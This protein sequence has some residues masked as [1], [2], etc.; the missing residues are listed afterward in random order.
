MVRNWRVWLGVAVSLF[1]AALFIYRVDPKDM[2]RTLAG[3]E[4]LLAIPGGLCYLGA[5]FLRSIRWRYLVRPIVRTSAPRLFPILTIGYALSNLLPL[6]VGELARAYYLGEEEGVS[7]TAA[8]ATV[9]VERVFDGLTLLFLMAAVSLFTP[10]LGQLGALK[11]HGLSGPIIIVVLSLPFLLGIAVLLAAVYF[12]RA[13]RKLLGLLPRR[14][15]EM[16][17]LFIEGLGALRG[18]K[19]LAVI[20]VLSLIVWLA[21]GTVFWVMGH[22]F[23]LPDLLGSRT[24]LL[25]AALLTMALANLVTALPSSSGGVGPF[26][27]FAQATLAFLGVPL[28]VA[29]AYAVAVHAVLILSVTSVGLGFLWWR[30]LPIRGLARRAEE[31]TSGTAPRRSPGD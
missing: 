20:F 22:A 14:L 12:P 9:V 4:Y 2:V 7:K 21:D 16:G 18:A 13:A 30:H 29:S 11:Y 31:S 17:G 1:F 19:S 10:V 25:P 15:G 6:R 27:F 26:E 3:A 8:L 23:G 28:A 5:M 24:A